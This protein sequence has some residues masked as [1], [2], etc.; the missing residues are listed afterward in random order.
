MPNQ[1]TPR[2]ATVST[3]TQ[4][5]ALDS[6]LQR[7]GCTHAGVVALFAEPLVK[8]DAAVVVAG[9]ADGPDHAEDEPGLDE[10]A[11]PRDPLLRD[12]LVALQ[13]PGQSQERCG[14]GSQPRQASERQGGATAH[15]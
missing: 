2:L 4:I 13:Q 5:V 1:R 9:G 3:H 11:E 14:A 15:R 12:R 8:L 6:L 10:L 7:Q